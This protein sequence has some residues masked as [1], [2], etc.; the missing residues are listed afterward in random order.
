MIDYD[1]I[2]TF[3]ELFALG[4]A[5]GLSGPCLLTCAPILVPFVAGREGNLKIAFFD[6]AIFSIGKFSAY[7][8]LGFLAGLSS[9]ILNKFLESS[10]V[11]LLKIFVGILMS[12]I[13]ILIIIGKN[14]QIKFCQILR[15]NLI[16]R[17]AKSLLIIGFVIGILPCAPL[18]V[19]LFE[20]A[21]ISKNAL[22]G[23][24]YGSAFG[25]GVSI[26][27]FLILAPLAGFFSFIPEK[28]F[29]SN[30]SKIIFRIFCGIILFILGIQLLLT[31]HRFHFN[32]PY[33]MQH[34]N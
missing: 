9:H 2:K 3:F 1:S 29:T 24:V 14:P 22:S 11:Y 21:L 10:S 17:S 15:K 12:I 8:L 16:E 27:P 26:T 33:I 31:T 25:I 5:W 30:T 20:I 13:G 6:T 28:F 34:S 32:L 23:L 4:L 7:I 18:L 19:I